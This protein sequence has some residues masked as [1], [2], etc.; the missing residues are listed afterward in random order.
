MRMLSLV[1]LGAAVLGGPAS[2]WG[3]DC[4]TVPHGDHPR[5]RLANG[6]VEAVLFLPDAVNGYYRGSRFDW[7]GVIGCLAYK[8][9]TYFGE[10]FPTYDPLLN[11][12]ITGPVEEFR[13]PGGEL[14]Y[15]VA[16]V[17]GRFLK[18]G[19]GVLR[20]VDE[21]PYSF[22]GA[23]PI[24]DGGKRT[25]KV[26][27]RSVTMTQEVRTEFGYGYRYTKTV[28]LDGDG[29]GMTLEHRLENLG[30]K[31]IVTEVYDHDFF[32]LDGRPTGPGMVVRLGF[33]PVPDKPFPAT[34]RIVGREIVFDEVVGGRNGPQGYLSGYTGGAGEYR[35]S[36]EDRVGKI[37]VEQTSES[38]LSKFYFWSTSR[39]ICPEAYV[40]IDVA[41]GKAQSWSIR[42]V[43][44]AE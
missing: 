41:P 4:R 43:F 32:M 18:I 29:A 19:V 13:A 35:I 1:V 10:W 9:H 39:T 16:G 28:R 20:R 14:G 17:G 44:R 25:T 37:G 23:Y 21:K 24:V 26:E 15:D 2:A 40:P 34:A 5:V 6:A 3:A 38:P 30:T 36:V 8:G 42:Y 27:K 33:A 31:P 22:G 12:A 7:A 11:D